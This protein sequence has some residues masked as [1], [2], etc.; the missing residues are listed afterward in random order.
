MDLLALQTKLHDTGHYHGALDGIGGTRT[1][2]AILAYLTDGPDTALNDAHFADAASQLSV[3][4]SYVR[5]LY[6]VESSGHAFVDG[7]PTILPEPHKFAQLTAGRY[8]NSHPHLSSRAWNPKLYPGSQGGRYKMLADMIILDPLAGFG[9]ASYGG[10]QILGMNHVRC[11]VP[12][13]AM[14]FAWQESRDEASQLRHFVSFIMTDAILWRALR[15][16]DWVTVAK[17]YNGSAYY[18]NRYDVK[19][20]RAVRDWS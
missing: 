7:R 8:N 9:C 19:L 10:F 6:A 1:R 16:G 18:K 11:G 15:A 12:T 20:A 17:R 3:P 5:A 4:V 14:D 13:N 2:D